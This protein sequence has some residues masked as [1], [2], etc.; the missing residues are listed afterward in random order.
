[1]FF[2]KNR[3]CD[4]EILYLIDSEDEFKL[5]YN[6]NPSIKKPTI[7]KIQEKYHYPN[8]FN[9]DISPNDKVKWE[10]NGSSILI[11][12]I[13]G[14]NIQNGEVITVTIYSI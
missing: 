4:R 14:V 7:I 6:I 3:N 2:T 13:K 9:V 12:P 8:G 10:Q 11:N 1:M 5:I